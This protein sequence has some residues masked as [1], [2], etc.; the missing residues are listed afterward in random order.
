MSGYL[1]PILLPLRPQ[2]LTC[3]VR[4]VADRWERRRFARVP[5]DVY[6]NDRCWVPPLAREYSRALSPD[7]NPAWQG[8]EPGLFLA[9]AR[10]LTW[11]D[12]TIGSIAAWFEPAQL[13]AEGS[14]AGGFGMFETVNEPEVAE[15][16]LDAAETWL[17]EHLPGLSTVTG[18]LSFEPFRP[19][20][21]LVDG[22]DA[23]HGAFLPYNPPYY[24]EMVEA[25]GYEP[26]AD[27]CVYTMRPDAVRGRSSQ[28]RIIRGQDLWSAAPQLAALFHEA[29]SQYP[30]PVPGLADWLT[31]PASMP[32]H[33][34]GL[35]GR[36]ARRWLFEQACVAAV[37][38]TGELVAAA[39][40]LPDI[41][42][43]LRAA[44]GRLLPL[45]WLPYRLV[46]RRP[47]SLR[48]L[49]AVAHPGFQGT[50]PILYAVLCDHA[51]QEGYQRIVFGPIPAGDIAA[52]TALTALGA[53]LVA[54]YRVYQKTY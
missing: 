52:R 12:T 34:H 6:R 5:W 3:A 53:G 44:R 20:G 16:L 11:A 47:R 15:A 37:E 32:D 46:L 18:P 25:A 36:L 13:E 41:G 54:T 14:V 33:S 27:T 45:G 38:T 7:H 30:E 49:P 19:S 9:E 40:A 2:R 8:L 21:L 51:A 31:E 10:N 28:V 4:A 42:P 43:G 26:A 48:V 39:V 24:A 17:F 22:F 29:S 35:E 23:C 50:E 1:H